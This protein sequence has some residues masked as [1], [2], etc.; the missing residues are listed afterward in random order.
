MPSTTAE[1]VIVPV[2]TDSYALTTD[3]RKMAETTT[4]IAVRANTTAREAILS[5]RALSG[6]P[7][8]PANPVYVHQSDTGTTW[9]NDGSGWRALGVPEV[10]VPAAL[11]NSGATVDSRLIRSVQI[12]PAPYAR[13]LIVSGS[14]YGA[15]LTGVWDGAMSVGQSTVD[16]SQRFARFAE[17]ASASTVSMTLI[18]ELPANQ[19]STARL[20]VRRV[21]GTGSIT[22]SAADQY[23]PL[24]VQ[25]FQ[26]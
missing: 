4:S 11:P 17:G 16:T 15:A 2:G 23:T 1:G 24:D 21:S 10:L 18:H 26:L 14:I 7:V 22:T 5:E 6:R 19:G 9:K 3:L 12:P 20:W 8:T 13:R 25:A